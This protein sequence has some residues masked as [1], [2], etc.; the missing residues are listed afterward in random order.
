MSPARDAHV[1]SWTELQSQLY[2]GSWQSDLKR[3]RSPFAFRGLPDFKAEPET[4]LSRMGGQYSR[5]EQSLLRNFRKYAHSRR[6]QAD[7][8]WNWIALAQHHG[9]P[10]RLLDWSFS[11][12][13]ALHF[14]TVSAAEWKCDAAIWCVDCVKLKQRLPAKLQT[15]L[16]EE[17]SDV[18]TV[19]MLDRAAPTLG[20]FER[21]SSKPFLA[22]FEPPS[23]DDRLVNQA[24]LFSV[25]SRA[26]QSVSEWLRRHKQLFRRIVI[27]AA[28]KREIRDKLDQANINERILFPG[29]DGLSQWLTRYYSPARE[30]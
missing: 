24:A 27:P 15:L 19:D 12:Y 14:A 23:L 7:S 25:T 20:A 4:S 2:E 30:F 1:S 29:L 17:D 10:T 5:R 11:P 16:K 18:L 28:L 9:L 8:L 21:L 26:D 22:F 3:F 13:V 6:I